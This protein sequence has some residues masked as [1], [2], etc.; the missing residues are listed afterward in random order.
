MPAKPNKQMTV[1]A[2]RFFD[3]RAERFPIGKVAEKL[4]LCDRITYELMHSGQLGHFRLGNKLYS[5][6]ADIDRYLESVYAP[7]RA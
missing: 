1:G 3:P 5:T 6:Q 7:R 4:G 2:E